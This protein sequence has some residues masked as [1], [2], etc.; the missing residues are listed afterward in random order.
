M[1]LANLQLRA[2]HAE[3]FVA[4][5][6]LVHRAFD[7]AVAP[8]LN[9]EGRATF[10]AY[11][12]SEAIAGR[13]AFEH[14]TL[15][16]ERDGQLLGMVQ[17]KLPDHLCMLFVEPAAQGQGIGCALVEAIIA[18][19]CAQQPGL[20]T[21][22]VNASLN[23]VPAYQRYGFVPMSEERVRNGIRYVPMEKQLDA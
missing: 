20:R 12:V 2:P 17:L 13:H 18:L 10:Y 19:A 1:N 21:I 14:L 8:G 22:S 9:A 5:A 7:A 4:V 23:A 16:A 6:A 3:E 15:L 11:A